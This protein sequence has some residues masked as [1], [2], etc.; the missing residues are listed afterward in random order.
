MCSSCL[1]LCEAQVSLDCCELR[2]VGVVSKIFI[3]WSSPFPPCRGGHVLCTECA[4]GYLEVLRTRE[5][6]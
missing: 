2:A 5:K 3:A 6:S 4:S 1:E